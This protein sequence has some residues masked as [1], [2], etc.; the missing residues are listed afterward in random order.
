MKNL[1]LI[2]ADNL[3]IEFHKIK[4]DYII[5]LVK[6][7]LINKNGLGSRPPKVGLKA[8]EVKHGSKKIVIYE[9]TGVKHGW[10]K[11]NE[12]TPTDVTVYATKIC[13]KRQR[14]F[15]KNIIKSK[16]R[17]ELFFD[18]NLSHVFEPIEAL[19]FIF[20]GNVPPMLNDTV[21]SIEKALL[22]DGVYEDC[23]Y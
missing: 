3:K 18:N 16:S 7:S 14:F 4:G 11:L 2:I 8:A 23:P 5:G 10:V 12:F 15:H 17:C 22:F 6:K 19:S 9:Y 21:N 20:D 1:K 13:Y